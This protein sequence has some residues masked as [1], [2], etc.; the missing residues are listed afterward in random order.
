MVLLVYPPFFF[1]NQWFSVLRY[2]LL[3][4]TYF[5]FNHIVNKTIVTHI[6]LQVVVMCCT[7]SVVTALCWI[8][9]Q[10]NATEL[11]HLSQTRVHHIVSKNLRKYNIL[12]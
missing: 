6:D 8:Y 12:Q 1:I 11:Y 5:I 2:N 7:G 3:T 4:F 9:I 10:G